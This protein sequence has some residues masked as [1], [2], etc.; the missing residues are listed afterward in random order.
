[1]L[2]ETVIASAILGAL[3]I[4]IAAA[5][6]YL[7]VGLGVGIGLVLG[8]TN[9]YAI[10]GLLGQAAPFVAGSLLR[11][12]TFTGLGLLLALVLGVSA[13]P[14]MLGVGAAQLVMVVAGVRQGL[15]A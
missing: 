7:S 6:G 8:S 10:A 4:A 1:M 11:L 3:V 15:R 9:G 5:F 2:R 14:V 13:W 12:A